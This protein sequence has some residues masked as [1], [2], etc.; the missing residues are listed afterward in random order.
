VGGENVTITVENGTVFVNSAKV[1]TPNVLVANGVVHVID[2]Y[3]S[4][5]LFCFSDIGLP[6]LQP[7]HPF[8]LISVPPLLVE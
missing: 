4:P 2:G 1:I 7:I 8:I 6:S 3:V 5:S